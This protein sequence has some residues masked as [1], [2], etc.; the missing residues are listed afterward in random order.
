VP[1]L[2]APDAAEND[3]AL[4]ERLGIVL[5][6]AGVSPHAGRLAHEEAGAGEPDAHRVGLV[7]GDGHALVDQG[8]IEAGRHDVLSP[9]ILICA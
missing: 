3:V 4:A 1:A 9:R 8:L 6:P 7:G 5:P 2:V